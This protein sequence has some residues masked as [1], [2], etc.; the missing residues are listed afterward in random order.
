MHCPGYCPSLSDQSGDPPGT[1]CIEDTRVQIEERIAPLKAPWQRDRDWAPPQ[2]ERLNDYVTNPVGMTF[3]RIAAG[4][5]EMGSIDG[6]EDEQPVHPVF[7]SRPFYLSITPVTQ[8]QWSA[9]MGNNPSAFSGASDRP[10]ES[11]SWEDAQV[12]CYQLQRHEP[13]GLYRLP[14]EAEWEYAARAGTKTAY[15]F[16][17]DVGPLADH[18]W[19]LDTTGYAPQPVGQ[20]KANTWGLY[21]M[22]GNVWEWVHDWYG[23]YDSDA[24]TDPAGPSRGS[25]RVIRGGSWGNGQRNCRSSFRNRLGPAMRS[26]HIGFRLLRTI[27]PP[28]G[29]IT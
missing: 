4:T 21:D 10:V 25:Y 3:V 12:F 23:Q 26:R 2:P 11:V 5:F 13:R 20:L 6:Y 22:Y 24:V 14:T 18:A 27:E 8:A 7:I 9:V 17:N 16:G 19:Y 28:T 1:H 29:D 15:H